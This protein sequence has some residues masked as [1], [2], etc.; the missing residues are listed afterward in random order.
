MSTTTTGT[1][2][3]VGAGPGDPELMTVKARR[4]LDEADVVLHDS[5]VGDGVIESIPDGTR[6]ENVGKR[7]DGERTP[8]AEINDRLVREAKAGRDVVRLKGGDPTIFARGGEEAEHLARHGVPFEVVPGITSAIAAPGV[9]GI[10]PTHR[11]HAST[12]AVVTG[13][14]D[15]SKPDSA[16][17]WDALSSLVD[18]GGTLVILMGV[19]RLPDNVAALREGGVAP[20]TPVAMVERATLPDER[21]VTGTLDT[22]VDRAEEAS[23]DPPAV[24]VVGQVV[25]VRET[26][27]HCLGDTDAVVDGPSANGSEVV[28]VNRQ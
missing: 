14:E 24:T 10:P 12:L 25:G 27:A 2:F 1:V 28:E 16:L 26:V 8:Q 21:T 7:A 4:L 11:D 18:A 15:P 22:I 17:D 13:H 5:L 19:G 9:A 23:I 3:L 6:V 20:D